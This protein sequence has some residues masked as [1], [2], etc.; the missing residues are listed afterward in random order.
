MNLGQLEVFVAIVENGSLTEAAGAVGLTQSAVSY[1]LSRLE[2]ELGVT[3]LERGRQGITVTRIGHELLI[4]ARSVLSQVEVIHQKAARERGLTVGKL[5]FGCIPQVPPRMLTGILRSFQQQYPDVEVVLFE[6]NSREIATWLHDGTVDVGSV[7]EPQL[8]ALSVQI[9]D[10]EMHVLMSTDHRFAAQATVSI[11]QALHEPLIGSRTE[12]EALVSRMPT[13][14]SL[15][16]RY[17]VSEIS[18]IYAMVAEGLG[19][20][21]L[22]SM[23]IDTD[24][25]GLT[26]R[27]LVPR[28]SLHASLA[29]NVDSPLAQVFLDSAARWTKAHG[30]RPG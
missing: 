1:S 19:V 24:L 7:T 12:L 5:R 22:P 27:P 16:L 9:A 18:T 17:Q 10:N 2:A 26:S 11:E 15:D 25:K 20:S 8:Y 13:S 21:I 6:G 23:L 29:S 30:Y 4:H 28:V 14:M 3:L